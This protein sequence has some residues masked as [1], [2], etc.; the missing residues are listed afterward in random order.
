[1]SIANILARGYQLPQMDSPVNALAQVYQLQN[2]Q[3]ANAIG[4][5]R[6]QAAQEEMAQAAQQRNA[7]AQF[8]QS[9]PSPQMQASQAALQGGG[10]PT[11]Q[12][13]AQMR[14]VDPR[15]QMLHGAM[16]SGL[17][18]PMDYLNQ[19][20]PAPK[21][22]EYKVVGGSL[23]KIG[24]DGV[25]EAYRAPEKAEAVPSA[26]RE[27]QFAQ[28]QGYKGSF[29]DFQLEQKRAGAAQTSVNYSQ[30]VEAMDAQ[31]NRVFIRTTKNGLEPA[32]VPGVRPP[33]SAAEERTANERKDRDRQGQQM[34]S[35]IGD[36]RRILQAGKAT[37]SGIGNVMDAAGRSVGVTTK[38]AQDAARLEALSGW[39]VAN[40]PRMEGPQSN[41]DVQNYTTMAGRVGDRTV[42]IAERLAALSEVE[43]LQR[44]YASINGTPSAAKPASGAVNWGDLK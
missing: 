18:A 22:P 43:T 1:M 19:A 32:I 4:K 5:M 7:L 9:I 13:A 40:V 30:P 39:L 29:Q 11:V 14:P 17:V 34:L 23:V 24:Q 12:N 6:M 21:A 28:Q 33:M 3:Q 37:D 20:M 27:Y 38:G 15:L 41:I 16:R 2:A 44:K 35:A 26:V 25:Q 31:G 36:A 8:Q 42:P 10:G